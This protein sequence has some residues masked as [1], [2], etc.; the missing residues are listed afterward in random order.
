MKL[1]DKFK[2]VG[3][4]GGVALVTILVIGKL[5]D[6]PVLSTGV[7]YVLTPLQKVITFSENETANVFSYFKDINALKDENEAL[8]AANEK[9]L[10][11]NTMLAQYKTQND[12]LKELLDMAQ[13][14][15]EYKGIGANVIGKD[16]SNWYKVFTIDKGT[17]QGIRE[18][19]VVLAN[20]GLVGHVWEAS[21]FATKGLTDVQSKVLSIIDDRSSVS[22]K[23]VRTGDIG[24]V[25]G[26]IELGSQGLCVLEINIES[27]VV[28]GDQIVTSH[29]SSIYPPGIPIG[30]V[31]EVVD[32]KNGLTRYAYIKPIADFKHLEQVLIINYD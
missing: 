17:K 16:S 23:V 30:I 21:D 6:I 13:L 22:A 12:N 32:S 24:I 11:D 26:D 1:D 25:N 31:E 2:R 3:I 20:G 19:S 9:L 15:K 27:E 5:F 7:N 29:L 14:Y 8:K 10:Y 28:V 18:N 4:I